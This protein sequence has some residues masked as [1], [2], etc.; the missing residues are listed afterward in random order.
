[1]KRVKNGK[2]EYKNYEIRNHGYYPPDKHN[3]WEAINIET[4]EADFH[5]ETKRHLKKLI[6]ED[7]MKPDKN[8]P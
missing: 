7:R 4:R 1:M 5:A 6:D 8:T 2:Y 3:W